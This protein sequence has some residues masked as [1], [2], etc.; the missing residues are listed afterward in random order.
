MKKATLTELTNAL[1]EVAYPIVYR[2]KIHPATFFERLKLR[3]RSDYS[4]QQGIALMTLLVEGLSEA[5]RIFPADAFK[6]REVCILRE[7]LLRNKKW[8]ERADD[9]LFKNFKAEFTAYRLGITRAN[10]DA[11]PDLQSFT[12][13]KAFLYNYLAHYRH[14]LKTK[15]AFSPVQILMNGE[16]VDWEDAKSALVDHPD[17]PGIWP[18]KYGEKGLKNDDFAEWEDPE[19]RAYRTKRHPLPGSYVFT[20]CAFCTP[21]APRYSGEHSWFRLTT[22]EGKVYE[23]GKYRPPRVWKLEKALVNFPATIQSPDMNTMW[24]IEPDCKLPIKT[25]EGTKIVE[26]HFEITKED[27]DRGLEKIKS[28]KQ[29]KNL[30][31][32]L[33]DDSCVVMV[34]EVAAA[35][36]I[37]LDTASSMLKLYF[38]LSV[39]KRWNKVQEKLPKWFVNALYFFPGVVT[40]AMLCLFLGA[41]A[42]FTPEGKRHIDTLGD[43]FNPEKSILH[44]PWYLAA[45]IAPEVEANRPE[46][47]PFGIPLKNRRSQK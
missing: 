18:W 14:S 30:T 24:P 47:N 12:D 31:F 13:T 44:H 11:S 16:Y 34:N 4:R 33:F 45:V 1:D 35:C 25:S 22:P 32:G 40:N 46:G 26:L 29:R 9:Q 41:T 7:F 21:K 37:Q 43:L 19:T 28:I 2:G 5:P 6:G 15:D 27:F 20:F 23:F 36:G 39:I 42:R 38:P 3:Y 17:V 8:L 10:M